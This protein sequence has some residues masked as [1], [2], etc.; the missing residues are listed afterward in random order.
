MVGGTERILVAEDDPAVL[1]LTVDLLEGLGYRVVSA[2]N[3]DEAMAILRKNR[4]IDLLFSDVIM[5]GGTNGI[6]LAQIAQHERPD[7]KILLTSG[8]VGDKAVL[9]VSE[10]LIL[11]KPYSA[12]VLAAHLRKLLDP[13]SRTARKRSSRSAGRSR[14]TA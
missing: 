2:T 1:K 12:S 5:P 3:A 11:D 14:Q 13:P 4:E 7:L 10:H 6:A 8:F 9:G